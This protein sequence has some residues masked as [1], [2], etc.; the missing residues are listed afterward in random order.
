VEAKEIPNASYLKKSHP[1]PEPSVPLPAKIEEKKNI[2]IAA[3][4]QHALQENVDNSDSYSVVSSNS[5]GNNSL[6]T[7]K[8]VN[9]ERVPN[10]LRRTK[11]KEYKINSNPKVFNSQH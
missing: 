11:Q 9:E 10:R 5:T 1:E 7:K 6:Y 4:N 2:I 3:T 8:V